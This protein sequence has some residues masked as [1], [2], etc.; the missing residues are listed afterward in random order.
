MI[1]CILVKDDIVWE[2][3]TAEDAYVYLSTL[4]SVHAADQNPEREVQHIG[5]NVEW[6]LGETVEF[7]CDAAPYLYSNGI[8]WAVQTKKG[9]MIF[10]RDSKEATCCNKNIYHHVHSC[11]FQFQVCLTSSSSIL[12][13]PR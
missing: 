6:E 11:P 5:A 9:K 13:H 8:K 2:T 4:H 1:S 7:G 3:E 12:G 10:Q